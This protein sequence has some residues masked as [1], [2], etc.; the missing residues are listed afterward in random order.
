MTV[1]APP[2]QLAL[3]GIAHG[4]ELAVLGEHDQVVGAAGHLGD[5]HAGQHRYR[6]HLQLA[7]LHQ[8][9]GARGVP[10]G[11]PGPDRAQAG[12]RRRVRVP[13]ADLARQD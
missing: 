4:V 7:G 3:L 11:A 9:D 6:R 10:E 1:E 12:Q 5:L 8:A 13:G 2:A